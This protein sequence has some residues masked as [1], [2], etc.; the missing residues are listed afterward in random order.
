MATITSIKK[1]LRKQFFPTIWCA[2][3]GNGI[4]MQSILRAI[5]NIQIPKDDIAMV[6]GI[7]CSSRTPGY[8]DF[9]TLHIDLVL[10]RN[11]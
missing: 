5:D 2:G 11:F 7:G 1:Y 10:M 6:S 9:N 3:C 4:I 8:C